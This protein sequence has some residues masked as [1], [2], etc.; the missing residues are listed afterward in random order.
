MPWALAAAAVGTIAGAEISSSGAK[1]AA[2]TEASAANNA[3]QV[4]LQMF[5][6]TQANEQPFL[7]AGTNA[8]TQLQNGVGIGPG[9]GG[10]G[11]GS[12]NTPYGTPYNP[13]FQES[14]GYQFQLQ[15][16]TDA[17]LNAASAHGGALGGNSLKALTS[18]GTGLA[19]QD[20]YNYLNNYNT[21]YWNQYNAYTGQQNQQFNQ[22]QTLAGSGQNAAANLGSLSS[23]TAG[24][25]GN[26]I[27]GAGNA[28][29]AGTVASANTT[30]NALNNLGQN[31]L[32][33]NAISGGNLFGSDPNALNPVGVTPSVFGGY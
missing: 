18:Y 3:T 2:N 15:Q 4:Q 12:L 19:N 6:Q 1:S 16:G 8:L 28:S 14:P 23:Q 32:L 7:A 31:Y 22:L 27:I 26:N 17:A 29:A 25:V 33:S 5:D 11:T 24:A 30:G 9:G 13:Q 10:P 20:Y 21:Q